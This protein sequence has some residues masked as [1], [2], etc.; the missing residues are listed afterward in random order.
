MHFVSVLDEIHWKRV[1]SVE[2]EKE[3]ATA[4]FRVSVAIDNFGSMSRHGPQCRD[5]GLWSQG[6]LCHERGFP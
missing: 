5:M 6:L 1:G 4:H 2:N 3:W